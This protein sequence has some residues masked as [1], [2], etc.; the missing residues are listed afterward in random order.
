I[1][2][3]AAAF[4]KMVVALQL[5]DQRLIERG[6]EQKRS[7]ARLA[8]SER[9]ALVGQML[10]RITHE[11]RNPLNALSLNAELL[12]DELTLLKAPPDHISWELLAIVSR[13]I[14]RLNNVTTHYLQLARR[15]P[16]TP[17]RRSISAII[18]ESV[19]LLAA[20]LKGA[21][22]EV[23]QQFAEVEPQLVDP[24][25]LRQALINVIKTA[26]GAGAAELTIGLQRSGDCVE[27]LVRDDGPGMSSEQLD[28]A[29][30]PF[31]TTKVDGTGLGLAITKE[32]IEDHEGSLII[33]SE[34]GVGTSITMSLPYSEPK[35]MC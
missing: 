2:A 32:I 34:P 25:Q 27:I 17:T 21:K 29:T 33:T 19:K 31:F 23:V 13:E 22:V 20:E 11:V 30:N 3:L 16:A 6:E 1:A 5:R 10:A 14:E 18:Q 35:P 9:L 28:Q 26:V 24:D 7:A 4:N 15:E 12:S 8:R